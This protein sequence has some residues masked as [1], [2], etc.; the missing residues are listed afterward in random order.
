MLRLIHGPVTRPHAPIFENKCIIQLCSVDNQWRGRN[1]RRISKH[2]KNTKNVYQTIYDSMGGKPL[3]LG[4][5]HQIS[6][7]S[8]IWVMQ[9]MV[10][11]QP[12]PKLEPMVSCIHP[13]SL[14]RCLQSVASFAKQVKASIHMGMVYGG[15]WP[16]IQ[17]L[18]LHYFHKLYIIVYV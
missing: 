7:Q 11:Y 17:P 4:A 5:I 1:N 12:Y 2:W 15:M 13:P 16:Y 3:K 10:Y 9:L 6:V 8:N 14:E 18:F